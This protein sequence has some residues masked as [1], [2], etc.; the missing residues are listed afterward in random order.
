MLST[1]AGTS[2]RTTVLVRPADVKQYDYSEP[3]TNMSI[4]ILS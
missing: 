3:T 4:Y 2:E 1:S